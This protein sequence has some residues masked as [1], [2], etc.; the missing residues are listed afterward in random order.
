MRF[1]P[2]VDSLGWA[3]SFLLFRS[4]HLHSTQ[5]AQKR[6]SLTSQRSHWKTHPDLIKITGQVQLITILPE[7][8]TATTIWNTNIDSQSDTICMKRAVKGSL[9]YFC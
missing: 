5:Q 9:F 7:V 3:T 8:Y 6:L 4:K 1:Y 2:L